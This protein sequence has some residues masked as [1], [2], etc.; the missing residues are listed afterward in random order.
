MYKGKYKNPSKYHIAS[1]HGTSLCINFRFSLSLCL[2]TTL[3]T[4]YLYRATLGVDVP[5]MYTRGVTCG[6]VKRNSMPDV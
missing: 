1:M 5:G 3:Q 2:S 4:R 6:C